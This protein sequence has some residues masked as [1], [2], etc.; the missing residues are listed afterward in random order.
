MKFEEEDVA[1]SCLTA[2]CKVIVIKLTRVDN[3]SSQCS[4]LL[5]LKN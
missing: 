2:D 3:S 5:L 1:F 4:N